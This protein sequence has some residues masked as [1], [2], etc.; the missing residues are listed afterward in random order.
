MERLTV[1]ALGPDRAEQ[2]TL[3]AA[4][5]LRSASAVLLR[6]GLH[7]AADWMDGQ[8]VR[9]ETLDAL[10]ESADDFDGLNEAAA[11]EILRKMDGGGSLC[12]GVPDPMTDATVAELKKSGVAMRVIAG[13]TQTSLACAGALESSLPAQ[14]GYVTLAAVDLTGFQL[15]PALPLIITELNSRLLAGEVKVQLLTLYAPET[16]VLLGRASIP[17]EL[18]DR[19]KHYDH[20][21]TVYIPASPLTERVRYTF[22]DLLDVMARLRRPGDGCPW[23]LE[24]TH[25]TLREYMIEEAYELVDAVNQG[26]AMRIAD[27]LGDVL[28]QV[29]FHAQVA[30][31][32]GEFDIDDVTTAIC[33]KMI[34]RHAHIF[35][36]IHCE[37]A[38]DVLKSWENIKKKE[39]GLRSAAESMR[40][41]PGHLP[42]LMRA[43]KVQ[44]K[45]R[46]V[47]FDWDSP[48][49]ALDKV[50]EEAGEVRAELDVGRDPAEELGDLLFAAVNVARLAGVQSEL[51]LGE[52]TAKF[53]RRF[54]AME[55]AILADGKNLSGMTLAEMDAYWD[56][57]KRA[58]RDGV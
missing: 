29:V 9:Y 36:D 2:L 56:A 18:L 41:I 53:V 4:D 51:A 33:H 45:A 24:Q 8:G 38:D 19:Q 54:E 10:Y 50:L 11:A 48:L 23:D 3:E 34:T 16:Q 12:Y 22:A 49:L 6:T 13:V 5:A 35:G 47:G 25:E 46:Q 7:G 20:L 52:A 15:N 39:K 43:G 40:D 21:T 30:I 57:V 31:E 17:L 14:G 42:A 27:E 44:K 58:E 1:V 26:D 37:T 28:L 55:A 32:H